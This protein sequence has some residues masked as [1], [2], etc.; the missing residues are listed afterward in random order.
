VFHG[1]GGRFY[2][3]TAKPGNSIFRQGF[4]L[5]TP[6]LQDTGRVVGRELLMFW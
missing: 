2:Y 1:F 6:R 3:L 5:L 4:Q